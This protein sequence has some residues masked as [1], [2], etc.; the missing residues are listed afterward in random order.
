MKHLSLFA[1]MLLVAALT[2]AGDAAGTADLVPYQGLK[3]QF[4]ISIP[5]NW[6]VYDQNAALHRPPGPFGVVQFS[7]LDVAAVQERLNT[8]D[9]D[10]AMKDFTGIVRGETPSFAVDRS[11]SEKGMACDG[12]SE[13]ALKGLVKNIETDAK[14]GNPSTKVADPEVAAV[15]LG[16]CKG[17]RVRLRVSPSRGEAWIHLVYAVSDGTTLYHFFVRNPESLFEKNRPDF[18]SAVHTLIFSRAKSPA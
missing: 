17:Q 18:E 16:G 9:K 1:V 11:P 10:Q 12:F 3:D 15:D 5:E 14:A 13:K 6:H 7:L 8:G 2:P 4:V